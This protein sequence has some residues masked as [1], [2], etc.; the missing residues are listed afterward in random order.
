MPSVHSLPRTSVAQPSPAPQS[1]FAFPINQHLLITTPSRIL[2]WDS[3][4]L[5]ELFAS[6][7]S[8]IAAATESKDGTGILAI[9]DKHVVVLHDTKRGKEKSWGLSAEEDEVRHLQYTKDSTSLFLSTKDTNAIQCYSTQ[10]QRLLSPPQTLATP[11][12]AL[13]VS[14]FGHLMISAQG[15][16]PVVFLKDLSTNSTATLLKPQASTS[17]I[18]IA[19]FHPDRANIFLLA[20]DDGTL[21]TFD[22]NR[23]LRNAGQGKYANQHRTGNAEIGRIQQLHRAMHVKAE[24]RP[25]AI[26]GA[27]FIPG[28]KLR[29]ITVGTDGRCKLVDFSNGANILRTWHGKA[30]LTSVSVLALSSTDHESAARRSKASVRTDDCGFLIAVGSHDGN[31][32]LYDSLGLRQDFRETS[33]AGERIIGVEWV[34]G[35]SP[36]C[37]SKIAPEAVGAATHAKSISTNRKSTPKHISVHPALRPSTT[38]PIASTSRQ[39]RRFTIHPDEAIDD[40]TVRHT[41][42]VKGGNVVSA[43]AGEYLDLFSP[44]NPFA[45]EQ[46]RA[47]RDSSFSPT[48]SR[49]RIDSQTFTN[50]PAEPTLGSR[51]LLS[52]RTPRLCPTDSHATSSGSIS[53]HASGKKGVQF[54]ASSARFRSSPLKTDRRKHDAESVRGR[55]VL[56]TDKVEVVDATTAANAKLLRDLRQM[57]TKSGHP[58]G[59]SVLQSY[60]S[61]QS[62][63][64]KRSSKQPESAPVLT[65]MPRSRQDQRQPLETHVYG[66]GGRWHTDSIDEP[67][68]NDEQQDDIWITSDEDRRRPSRR[69]PCFERPAARQTSRSRM[70]SKGTISTTESAMQ[71]PGPATQVKTANGIASTDD[72]TTARSHVSPDGAFSLPSDDVKSLFPRT[73]SK[74][75]RKCKKETDQGQRKTPN[76][77]KTALQ[78]IASNAALARR[79]SDPWTRMQKG[80]L[81]LTEP[82]EHPDHAGP[83]TDDR[84]DRPARSNAR[85]KACGGCASNANKVRV[86]EGEVAHM[87]GEILA[88]RAMLRRNGIPTPAA[89]QR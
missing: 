65:P 47:N 13:A 33:A 72:Y 69:Q 61:S 56:R 26:T 89:L 68:W 66:A 45:A 31:V 29:I 46:T 60:A 5:H 84:G 10:A 79:P 44:V 54:K 22:A 27:A 85:G 23:L 87:K 20:F 37:V 2:S 58:Q 39:S 80:K 24:G 34:S 38:N 86:L 49:P 53:V 52:S 78:E 21:A 74:S 57:S 73:S 42:K 43:E 15:Y 36:S 51:V 1:N 48:R 30:P 32:V 55:E 28:N 19:A 9:A 12:A 3:L 77:R 81:L 76:H 82:E 4:G 18:S 8:G 17:G 40:S 64:A 71:P 88:L 83:I 41:P 63:E 6:S 70:D 67:S 62:K 7:K 35:A 59:G 75:P 25:H 50:V 11:A 16:P 14:P